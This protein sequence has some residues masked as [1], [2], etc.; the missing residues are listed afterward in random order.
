MVSDFMVHGRHGSLD[1]MVSVRWQ[2]VHWTYV[3]V[4]GGKACNKLK[5]TQGML[6]QF[7]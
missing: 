3:M 7:C 1:V 5:L 6:L 4:Y 2:W